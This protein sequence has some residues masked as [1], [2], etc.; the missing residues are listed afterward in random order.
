MKHKLTIIAILIY[1]LSSCAL[2]TTDNGPLTIYDYDS[3]GSFINRQY[4]SNPLDISRSLLELDEYLGLS[5][6]DKA[7]DTTF[8]LLLEM[9]NGIYK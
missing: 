7:Q 4:S 2:N 5:E 3:Y 8:N 6:T 9:G 1:A